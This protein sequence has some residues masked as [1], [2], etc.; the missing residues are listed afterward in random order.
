MSAAASSSAVLLVLLGVICLAT[1]AGGH[2]I[3]TEPKARNFLAWTQYNHY[4]PDGASAGGA[5]NLV[6]VQAL[7]KLDRV[8]V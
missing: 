3:L 8:W 4:W 1:R 6:K 5:G 2:G 7:S